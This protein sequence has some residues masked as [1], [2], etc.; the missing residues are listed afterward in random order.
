MREPTLQTDITHLAVL[1]ALTVAAGWL[2]SRRRRRR[3]RRDAS[4]A[5]G[6]AGEEII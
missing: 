1:D 6:Y 4:P 3:R 5:P 2:L